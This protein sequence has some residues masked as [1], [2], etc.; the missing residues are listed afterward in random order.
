VN[1]GQVFWGFGWETMTLEAGFLAIFLGSRDTKTPAVLIW[2]LRWVLFRLMFGAGLIK[3]R[4]DPCWRDWTCMFYH[5]QTQPLPN[6]LSWYFHHLPHAVQKF[7][8]AYTLFVEI[9]VPWL[10]FAA[11]PFCYFAGILTV[12]FQGCLILSG[13]LS[14]LN[15]LTLVIC[16]SCFDDAFFKKFIPVVIPTQAPPGIL[17]K[18]ILGF[19]SALVLCLSLGPAVNLFSPRQMMNAS[20]EPLH[21]VNT[22]GA[23][24]AVTKERNE[25]ILEGTE[26]ELISALT[27]WREYEFKAKPGD[28]HRLPGVVAPYHLRLDWLLWFAAM[29]DW[30][31]HPWILNLIW[32][33]LQNDKEILKLIDKN[34][35]P[36]QPPRFIRAV[37]YNYRFTTAEEK[38]RTGDWW[39]RKP[40]RLYLPPISLENEL[41]RRLLHEAGWE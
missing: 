18:T 16:L 37:L 11:R 19:L 35:F 29:D 22:Y 2:F 5:Y 6:P 3:L 21:L 20:F 12:I 39:S 24:G 14:W 34:P 31:Y 40:L 27:K 17:R 41:F 4:G 8:T 13:N 28:V 15:Y 9:V 38:K 1:V 23:F 30:R 25:I 26:D 33:L 10:Y 32:K 7:Q 36:D